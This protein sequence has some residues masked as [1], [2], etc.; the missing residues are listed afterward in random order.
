MRVVGSSPGRGRRLAP[1]ASPLPPLRPAAR[2]AG[3]AHDPERLPVP[4]L[5]TVR[6]R[7]RERRDHVVEDEGFPGPFLALHDAGDARV[8]RG[9]APFVPALL[10]RE[11]AAR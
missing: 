6:A 4:A 2:R 11:L 9:D 8:L 1:K 10:A 5:R 3:L 7:P